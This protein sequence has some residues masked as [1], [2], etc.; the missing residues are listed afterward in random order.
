MSMDR[1]TQKENTD[2]ENLTVIEGTGQRLVDM[3]AR[4]KDREWGKKKTKNVK[5]YN[6][7]RRANEFEEHERGFLLV[8]KS[9]AFN[10]EHCG[11]W[12][13]FT[14]YADGSKKL[15]AANFCRHKFCPLCNWRRSLKLFGQVAKAVEAILTDKPSVRFLF[16]TFTIKNVTKEKL[17]DALNKMNEAYKWIF[18]KSKTYAPAK[19]L[20]KN[21]N[22]YVKAVEITYNSETDTYHPHIHCV[23]EVKSTYFKNSD[24]YINQEEWKSLWEGAMH[25]DYEPMVNVQA[26]TN[27]KG[28]IDAGAV[29]EVA[30]YPVK[31]DG[32]LAI[33]DIDKAARALITLSHTTANRRFLTFG[34][35][36]REYRRRL[37]HDDIEHGDLVHVETDNETVKDSAVFKTLWKYNARMG[38]YIN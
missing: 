23:V 16:V 4:G 8:S 21:V 35:D 3:S 25:L 29:A 30:K 31:V 7:V 19:K 5:M 33:E 18:Q 9:T 32:L 26:I 2:K 36:F 20:K 1:I 15:S 34:G 6:I 12:L 13:E 24:N 22:G 28:G 10:I 38:V 37:K 11:D 27:E 17:P 14:H